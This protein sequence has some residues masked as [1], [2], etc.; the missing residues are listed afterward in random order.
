MPFAPRPT[1]KALADGS[2]LKLQLHVLRAEALQS[3][4]A[5]GSAWEKGVD[6]IPFFIL[7]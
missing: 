7:Q 1:P 3:A 5:R 2:P 4:K 6:I